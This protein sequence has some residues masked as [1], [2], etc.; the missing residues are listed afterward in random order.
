MANTVD[1]SS[2]RAA[3]LR[4]ALAAEATGR[5]WLLLLAAVAGAAAIAVALGLG[6][7]L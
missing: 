2:S 1:W 7:A 5:E 3:L 6:G 4:S